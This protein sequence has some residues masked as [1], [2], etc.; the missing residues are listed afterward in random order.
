M[1]ASLTSCLA[2]P[3]TSSA[4]RTPAAPSLRRAS[5]VAH[6]SARPARRAASPRS[7]AVMASAG[8]KSESCAGGRGDGALAQRVP[9]GLARWAEWPQAG[10]AGAHWA[11][12]AG[13]YYG[14]ER[15]ALPPRFLDPH[16]HLLIPSSVFLSPSLPLQC[17]ARPW[18]TGP[19]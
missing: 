15:R 11:G 10:G 7:V 1:Q 2:G 4:A 16:H 5:L 18:M 3:I 6:K 13:L 12:E 14:R 9:E 17:A 8:E 19:P